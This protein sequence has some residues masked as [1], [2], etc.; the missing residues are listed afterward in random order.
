MKNMKKLCAIALAS[1][2]ALSFTACGKEEISEE[3]LAR[4][5]AEAQLSAEMKQNDY[6]GGV[7]RMTALKSNVLEV[8][9]GMKANNDIIRQDTPNTFWTASGYQDFVSNFL[10]IAIIND[11]KW[12]NEEEATWEQTLGAMRE[13]SSFTKLGDNGYVFKNGVSVFRNEKDDYSVTGVPWTMNIILSDVAYS[14]SGDATYRILYDCDKDWC[15]AYSTMP[16]LDNTPATTI[17]MFEYQ[18]ITDDVFVIQT[19]RE[20]LMVVLKPA[21]ADVDIR[22]REISEFY[23]SKLVAEGKRTTFEDF[24]PLPEKDAH[25]TKLTANIRYNELMSENPAFN[26]AGECCTR[27]GDEE[28]MFYLSPAEITREWVFEDKSLQQA[29]CYKEGLLMVTTYNKLSDSYERFIYAK[30]GADTTI[31]KEFEKLVEIK[32]L[33]GIV[34]VDIVATVGSSEA[35]KPA[36]TPAVEE[37][38]EDVTVKPTPAPAETTSTETNLV[39]PAPAETSATAVQPETVAETASEGVPEG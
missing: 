11:T 20:R 37:K 12:F 17:E 15:K 31:S 21:E 2:M 39:E 34:E 18:R 22:E 33:V 1:I 28:S 16:C 30:S 6:R 9:E 23:Y 19:S 10:D 26:E 14:Y 25:R 8:M 32:S 13:P 5:K 35:K 36:T 7:T 24:V 38:T 4:M 3:E 29:I 27:Y